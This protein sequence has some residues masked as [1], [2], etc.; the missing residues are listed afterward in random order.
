M[1]TQ[2]IVTIIVLVFLLILSGFFSSSETAL[3]MISPIRIKTMLQEGRSGA[4]TLYKLTQHKSR[5]LSTVLIGN[6]IVNIASSAIA[7]SLAILL[8]GGSNAYVGYSTVLLTL[9]VLLFGEIIPK[10]YSMVHCERFALF[11][12]GPIR[13]LMILLTPVIII[14]DFIAGFFLRLLRIDPKKKVTLLTES[15]LRTYVDE[16]HAEGIIEE[17]ARD[18]I[19]N[20]FDFGDAIAKDIMIP[21][22]DLAAVDVDAGYNEL[23]KIFRNTMYTRIPVFKEEKD[24]MIGLVNIKDFLLIP[25]RK[26]FTISGIL[27][28][29]YYTYETKKAADLFVEMR[30]KNASVAFV[31]NEYGETVGMIT[32]ED[33]LEEIVGEIRDEYDTDERDMITEEDD[34]TYLVDSSLKLDDLNDAIHTSFDSEMY[35]SI[36]GLVIE[37]LERLPK[38]GEEVTTE[39][40]Y[41]LSVVGMRNNRILKVR[42]RFPEPA[43]DSAVK[44]AD[45]EDTSDID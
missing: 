18:M 14:V 34:G 22:I 31:I 45:M 43:E 11:C 35:D 5:M 27:R 20:V 15:D 40:G 9:I 39:D 28:E 13:F 25:S 2:T 41:T 19:R 30:E 44:E 33:L 36:G 32:M 26:E 29:A 42:I 12:A 21:R 10:T 3:T 38:S 8:A 7:T 17:G 37:L 4:K 23:L 6:N 16:G 24:N 1:D